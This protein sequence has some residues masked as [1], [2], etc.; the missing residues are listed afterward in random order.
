[1]RLFEFQYINASS[2]LSVGGLRQQF[3][4]EENIEMSLYGA[5]FI[6][7]I[8]D[9]L[10]VDGEPAVDVNFHPTGYLILATEQG[11]EQLIENSKLQISMGAK[12]VVLSKSRL[13]QYFPWLNT[14]GIEAG[15]L[16]LEKEGWFDPWSLLYGFKRKAIK[17]GARF[18]KADV[19]GFTFRDVP[20]MLIAGVDAHR[21]KTLEGAVVSER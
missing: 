9:Y 18:I 6:Q 2:T 17:L 1:M 20:G 15:C 7:N 5:H 3:S 4:L 16:G 11:A 12:N 10:W 13:K 21:Y 19:K 14:D 8:N